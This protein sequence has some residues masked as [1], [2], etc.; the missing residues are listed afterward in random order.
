M[1]HASE[2]LKTCETAWSDLQYIADQAR[3]LLEPT[4]EPSDN[5]WKK[6]QEPASDDPSA[7]PITKTDRKPLNS[8]NPA[9]IVCIINP[10]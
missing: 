5:V 2:H 9:V 1:I 7:S 10:A 8:L 4:H 6:I 3:Q